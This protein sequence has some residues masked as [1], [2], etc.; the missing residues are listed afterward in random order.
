VTI[1]GKAVGK[2]VLGPMN[3]AHSPVE[4]DHSAVASRDRSRTSGKGRSAMCYQ[5]RRSVDN[6]LLFQ[7]ER[8]GRA[9]EDT[10]QRHLAAGYTYIARLWSEQIYEYS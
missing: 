9:S 1:N 5:M 10:H 3:L 2:D 4:Q 8:R 7:V 6:L